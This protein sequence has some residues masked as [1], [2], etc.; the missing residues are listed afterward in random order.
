MINFFHAGDTLLINKIVRHWMNVVG[1]ILGM[2]VSYLYVWNIEIDLDLIYCLTMPS[3]KIIDANDE[4][5]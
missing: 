4:S 1:G 5:L 2:D 3:A